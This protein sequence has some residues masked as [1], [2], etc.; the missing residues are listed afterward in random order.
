MMETPGPARGL[1]L[2]KTFRSIMNNVGRAARVGNYWYWVDPPELR[3][4]IAIAAIVCP[5]RYDVLVRRDFLA[6]YA[7][8][9]ELYAADFDAFVAQVRQGTYYR[10]FMESEAVRTK[11]D[12]LGNPAA[13]EAEFAARVRR[14][15]RLYESVTA[16]GFS[17]EQPI[18]LKT[19]EHLLPPTAD[20]LAP[21]TG[22]RVSGRYFLADGCHRLALL[23]AL[24]T[25]DLPRAFF[26]VKCF[27]SFSP[28]DSTSLLA[29]SL[30]LEPAAYF[31]FLSSYYCAPHVF[32]EGADFIRYVEE[33]KPQF[34]DEA[35]SVIRV[36]GYESHLA[37]RSEIGGRR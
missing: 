28:F 16:R 29:R 2:R 3:Q 5:L 22:K 18:I 21:P 11:R 12:L 17:P 27:R 8:H 37:R 14:A 19:A 13:L 10:W 33:R 9:R 36:D 20:K 30:A 31:A 1:G 25:V 35:L 26:R 23:M 32:E 6:F 15:A 24:G 7:G 4:G 34:L